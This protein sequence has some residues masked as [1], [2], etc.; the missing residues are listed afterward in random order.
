MYPTEESQSHAPDIL[1]GVLQVV[2]QVL[3]NQ[4][5]HR[6]KEKG[7]EILNTIHKGTS[8]FET[9]HHLWQQLPSR[10][11]LLNRLLEAAKQS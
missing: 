1:I 9:T 2:A 6:R 11:R 3:A 10:V 5:L 4:N 8:L 7:G